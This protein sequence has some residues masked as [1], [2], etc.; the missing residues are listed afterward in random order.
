MGLRLEVI[1]AI[2]DLK[3]LGQ[4]WD[5][6][7]RASG[8]SVF[9]SHLWTLTWFE[10][11]W[12]L[13][14][15]RVLAFYQKDEL[16]G[17]APLALY[18]TKLSRFTLSYLCLA[19]NVGETTEYHDLGFPFSLD[20][21]EAAEALLRGMRRLRW[22]MLQLRDLRC[23][24]LT[25]ALFQRMGK[26]WAAEMNDSKPC[27]YVTLNKGKE[28]LENF[29]PRSAKKVQRILDSLENEGRICFRTRRSPDSLAQA[30]DVYVEQHKRRWAAKGG[31]IFNDPRQASFLKDISTR[32]A[33]K[34]EMLVYEVLI[35]GNVAAQQFCILERDVVRLFKIGM[36]DDYRPYAPGYLS[37]Y[38]AMKETQEEGYAEYDLGPGPEEYK[39]KV[40]GVDRWTCN[41]HGKRGVALLGS[42]LAKLPGLRG[43]SSKLLSQKSTEAQAA[44][45][46]PKLD[47][48]IER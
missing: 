45:N 11:F 3:G 2:D 22:D 43:W 9:T 35:D 18:R 34:G 16:K 42:N 15:P 19:G 14:S 12:G 48:E 8:T 25:K 27:P 21:G 44:A 33:E 31:S 36:N 5:V 32:S 37:V 6:L 47:T 20:T 4:D 17:V 28:I 24:A 10:H 7:Q 46:K 38:Y 41:I 23:D 29:E 13:A 26:D 40:G 39:Y 1:T 30:V